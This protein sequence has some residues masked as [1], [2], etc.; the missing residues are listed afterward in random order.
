MRNQYSLPACRYIRFPRWNKPSTLNKAMFVAHFFSGLLSSMLK[1]GVAGASVYAQALPVLCFLSR[2]QQL[3][4]GP[5][6][7]M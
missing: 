1:D 5:C 6:M 7:N 4:L 2:I 3:V